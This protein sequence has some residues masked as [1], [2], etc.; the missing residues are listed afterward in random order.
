MAVQSGF[1]TSG[2]DKAR[3]QEGY[4]LFES[5]NEERLRL[6]TQ[7]ELL[8]PLIKRLLKKAGISSGMRVLDIGSGSGEMPADSRCDE[9]LDLG[10]RHPAHRSGTLSLPV[11]EG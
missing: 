8:A 3:H 11:E 6:M 7:A 4:Y 2:V 10:R 9:S 1:A 5:S